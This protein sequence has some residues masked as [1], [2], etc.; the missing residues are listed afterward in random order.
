M[1]DFD[2]A[3]REGSVYVP[4]QRLLTLLKQAVAYQIE[5]S[6]YHNIQPTPPKITTLLHDHTP[7][8][9]P[10][11][12]YKTFKGHKA[13]VKCARFVGDAGDMIVSGSSDNTCRVWKTSTGD[14]LGVLNGHT[15]RIWDV[16]SKTDGSFIASASGDSTVKVGIRICF[17]WIVVGRKVSILRFYLDWSSR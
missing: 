5:C 8:F 12:V 2:N 4:P 7:L 11:T 6:R 14:C 10:N 9:V 13:N 1:I 17:N 16:C 3:D 15:S